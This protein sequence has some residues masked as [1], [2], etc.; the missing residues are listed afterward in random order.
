LLSSVNLPSGATVNFLYDS[1]GRMTNRNSTA[2]GTVLFYYNAN[3]VL[4]GMTNGAGVTTNYYDSAGRL[5]GMDYPSGANVR[6]GLDV[7]DRITAITNKVSSGGT[8]YLRDE[9]SIRCGGQY[10]ECG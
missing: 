2:D 1:A 5:T 3:D 7:L 6:Y 4:A 10:D 9:V 8:A